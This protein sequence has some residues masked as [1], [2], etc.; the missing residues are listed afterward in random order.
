MVNRDESRRFLDLNGAWKFHWVKDPRKRP[1]TFHNK[2]YNDGK[3]GSIQV[4]ANW[5]TSGFGKPIY[6]DERYPF[7]TQWPDVPN[8]YNPVGTYRRWMEWNGKPDEEAI[9]HFAAAKS[10]L[11]VYVNGN[12]VGYSQ[13]SK[14]PAEF[15][16]DPYLNPGKNLIALQQFRWSDA[17]YLESQDM[18]RMSGIE[19]DVYLYSRPSVHI[20]DYH[21]RTNLDDSYTHGLF[22]NTLSVRNNSDHTV[23]RIARI[24]LLAGK[25]TLMAQSDALLIEPGKVTDYN[26]SFTLPNVKSWTAETPNRYRLLMVLED[27]ELDMNNQYIERP[28][29][30]K[31]VEISDGQVLINGKPV[32]FKGV[33]RH[34]TDPYTGHVVSRESMEKD[35]LLMKRNNINA[36]R[37]AHYPNDPYWLDLCDEYGLYVVDEANI[38]SHPLAIDPKTQLGNEMSWLPA[39]LSRLSRMYYRD[40]N[41]VSI[42][43]WS[44]GNEAGEGE[45]F[46]RAYQWLK[47][48]EDSRIVQYEPA[49]KGDYTDIYCPMYPKP[50]Y[51]IEH[52]S[53]ESTIPSIMI[54]YAHAMGNSVGNLQDYWDIIERYDNL[55]GGYIWDWVD[56]SLEY[57]DEN[58][59]P[60][61][62]YGHDYHPDLPTDG[63][64][65]NNGLVDPYRNPHP[66]LHEVKKVYQPVKFS[67]LGR[68]RVLIKNKNFFTDLS[69]TTVHWKVLADGIPIRN[70]QI[71]GLTVPPQE[72]KIIEIQE[73][74][75]IEDHPAEIILELQLVQQHASVALPS[76][77][78]IAFDQFEMKETTVASDRSLVR[79]DLQIISSNG[80]FIMSNDHV[81]LVI[82]SLSGELITW[83]FQGELISRQPI[84]PHF[85]RPPTDND[86]GNGMPEWAQVWQDATYQSM[87]RLVKAPSP[88]SNGVQ[89]TVSHKLPDGVADCQTR[90]SLLPNGAL[91]VH[92]TFEPFQ[93]DLPV[94]P[95][96]GVNLT[97]PK[98]FDFIQWYGRGPHES[99]RDRKTGARV[100]LYEGPVADQFHRYSRPQE[101]GN[102][103]DLRN[104]KIS[105]D[106]LHISIYCKQGFFEASAWP[107]GLEM[108]DHYPEDGEASA[109]GLVPVTKKHG[110]DIKVTDKV[111]LNLDGMQMGVG[112]DTSWGRRVHEQ[113]TI[114]PK[115][116]AFT[117]VLRPERIPNSN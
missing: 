84:K 101:T 15:R 68:G 52:G 92:L 34:E 103:T 62:A 53:S 76:G 1:R 80:S 61:L 106:R 93:E 75:E 100:G 109:S 31:R 112:G 8:D 95:R 65:L 48:R 87:S 43:S 56:Q 36:V 35:I 82:D 41:H 94:L 74:V 11:Y 21:A 78:E 22:H 2:E 12:Y 49:G 58:G 16:I 4:P 111:Q 86:L 73:I 72:K 25:D 79:N 115:P 105:S 3:W 67:H 91:E 107:F 6:L 46:R 90:I 14:T 51:L 116:Y 20:A 50:E 40:R 96:L 10:A 17:S 28:V 57:K 29:G 39:H 89:F 47:E 54:E 66:H 27:P 19:R 38:E 117:F 113:Y 23:S 30:F 55:Q 114:P 33:N 104:F 77:H 70:G 13:G 60:Y 44:L 110:A 9:L 71:F 69:G 81:R 108:L 59:N 98:T 37:S 18:L 5:E 97:L 32:Y 26:V 88:I 45:I 64:F 42:Y 99:Y 7:T 102:K 24:A 63:N 83:E 85:W